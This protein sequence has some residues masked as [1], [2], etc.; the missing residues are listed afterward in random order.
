PAPRTLRSGESVTL[1]PRG[2]AADLPLEGGEILA[3]LKRGERLLIDNGLV[4]LRIAS[5]RGKSVSARVV[6]GGTVS[7]RK[8]VNL[9][10]TELPFP[11]SAKDR[12]DVA[13]AVEQGADFLALSYVGRGDEVGALRSVARA[14]GRDLP[15]VA[16][17]ERAL[18]VAH[19]DEIVA[20]ADAVMVARG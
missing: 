18:A 11:I 4:E 16:K 12:R 7:T 3:H 9:P 17:L 15:I 13:F 19:L 20:A 2:A 14:A 5:Q 8:G 6:F 10:D 1:G